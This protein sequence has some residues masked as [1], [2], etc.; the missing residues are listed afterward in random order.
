[1][2][3]WQGGVDLQRER[4]SILYTQ[5]VKSAEISRPALQK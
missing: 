1:M 3:G 5:V 2:Q 4:E